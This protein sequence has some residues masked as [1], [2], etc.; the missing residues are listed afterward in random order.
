[1]R[2]LI[3]LLIAVVSMLALIQPVSAMPSGSRSWLPPLLEPSWVQPKIEQTARMF[4][5]G[6]WGPSVKLARIDTI[7]YPRKI[8]VVLTFDR[9]VVCGA[10]SAPAGQQVPHGLIVRFSLDRTTHQVS[11]GRNIE[12]RFCRSRRLCLLY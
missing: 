10:C 9:P 4:W 12:I 5:T 8:A 11:G 3:G 1:M 2:R 7:D 6:N